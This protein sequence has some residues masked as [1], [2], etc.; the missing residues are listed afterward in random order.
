MP[1]NKDASQDIN[2]AVQ[3]ASNAAK[4]IKRA[5]DMARRAGNMAGKGA[6]AKGVQTAG[7]SAGKAGKAAISAGKT[8]ASASSA[9]AAGSAASSAAGTAAAAGGTTAS[10]PILPIV[11][12]VVIILFLLLIVPTMGTPSTSFNSITQVNPVQDPMEDPTATWDDGADLSPA[13]DAEN[14]A[15]N[16]LGEVLKTEKADI[17]KDLES[18]CR[19]E[20]VDYEAT[21]QFLDV[22]F[23]EISADTFKM[24]D[25][26]FYTEEEFD[27]LC[28]LAAY[29][30][31]VDHLLGKSDLTAND[32]K[33]TFTPKGATKEN[34]KYIY[35]RLIEEGYT[36]EVACAI[37][38][39]LQQESGVN[40]NS[41]QKNGP[42]RGIAQWSYGGGRWNNL[43]KLANSKGKPWTDLSVQTDFLIKEL[44]TNGTFKT[45]LTRCHN[46]PS[47]LRCDYH[48]SAYAHKQMTPSSYK[49]VTDIKKATLIFCNHFEIPAQAGVQID[50]RL[51]YANGFYNAFAVPASDSTEKDT[52]DNT[53]EEEEVIVPG[54]YTNAAFSGINGAISLNINWRTDM[55]IKLK[56]YLD[57][58]ELYEISYRE[59]EDGN[60]IEY[61]AVIDIEEGNEEAVDQYRDDKNKDIV[62]DETTSDSVIMDEGASLEDTTEKAPVLRKEK[63]IKASIRKK[64]I[65][66]FGFQAFGVTEDDVAK[67]Y[68]ESNRTKGGEI[69]QTMARNDLIL[70]HDVDDFEADLIP[71]IED[72]DMSYDIGKSVGK[73]VVETY[74]GC[75]GKK[76]KEN[77]QRLFGISYLNKPSGYNDVAGVSAATNDTNLPIGTVLYQDGIGL[78]VITNHIPA[79]GASRIVIF[80]GKKHSDATDIQKNINKYV[81]KEGDDMNR[82]EFKHVKGVT[83]NEALTSFGDN[84][85][86]SNVVS[87]SFQRK[88]LYYAKTKSLYGTGSGWCQ[89]WV[90]EVYKRASGGT[91][92]SNCC[93]SKCRDVWAKK[94]SSI[95]VGAAIYADTNYRCHSGI[96]GSCGRDCGHVGI[97]IGDGKVVSNIGYVKTQSLD[98]WKSYYGYGGWSWNGFKDPR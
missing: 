29:S 15:I 13:Q 58:N 14:E 57:S 90:A 42:G 84:I 51:N 78:I 35:D 21:I 31:S 6:A 87:S 91:R 61:D 43:I 4:N 1:G 83:A 75:N 9:G 3:Q 17:Y 55:R 23:I 45:Y 98:S 69:V 22:N 70:L 97:Y 37:L 80:G 49:T 7:G 73:Y 10:A 94:T 89:A 54:K 33:S 77:R 92:Y 34:A 28:L 59:D 12:V 81:D 38:G 46:A 72:V 25:K 65:V 41:K 63:Y 85:L 76:C 27:A 96:C 47:Y 24:H 56:N 44:K 26:G 79:G 71:D 53:A 5:T 8:A 52:D 86:A 66:T 60:V 64:E 18:K 30:I 39:N 50:K 82:L 74:C 2:Q 67:L 36:P 62:S 16:I 68:G 93:A 48:G 95:P 11:I 20:G 32:T 19:S 40:P 88:I